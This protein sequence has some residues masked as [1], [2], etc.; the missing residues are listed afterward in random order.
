MQIIYTI[1]DRV[2]IDE[3]IEVFDSSGILRPTHDR[4]RIGEMIANANL[5][6]TARVDG[7]LVGIA[8]S[9]TDRVWVTYL[10][11]LAVRDEYQNKGVGKALIDKTREAVGPSAMLLLLAAPSA[12]KYYPKVGFIE[13]KPA[14]GWL[15][16]REPWSR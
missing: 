2:E 13:V 1:G 6:V 7:K 15:M 11:D 9:L 10:S 16:P 12:E 14:Q 3:L 4:D 8:R 5:I